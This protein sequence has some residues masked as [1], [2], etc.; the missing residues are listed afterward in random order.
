MNRE[1]QSA[2]ENYRFIFKTRNSRIPF[3]L[4]TWFFVSLG[5][6]GFYVALSTFVVKIRV[7]CAPRE[8]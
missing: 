3:F 4:E 5:F 8:R 7:V 6:A 1:K 2:E